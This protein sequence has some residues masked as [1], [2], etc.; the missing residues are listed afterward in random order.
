MCASAAFSPH[1]SVALTDGDPTVSAV[2][3]AIVRELAASALPDLP[4][5]PDLNEVS[6]TRYPAGGG[7]I[8]AHRDPSTYG[9]LIAILTLHGRAT[10][11]VWD[12]AVLGA[13]AEMLDRGTT[14]SEWTAAAGDLVL[15]RGNG[16]PVP[17]TRSPMH[18]A[19]PPL[20]GERMILTFRHNTRG[21][22]A[23]YDV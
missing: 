2:D 20:E 9:G 7:L 23:G 5:I 6:W 4:A 12:G 11:R 13:P 1:P 17:G 10:F 15:L 19:D 8:T 21:A 3:A 14:S 22:G 16:W 18:A